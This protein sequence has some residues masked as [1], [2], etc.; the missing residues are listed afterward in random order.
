MYHQL[1]D[2][3]GEIEVCQDPDRHGL[4][5]GELA[6]RPSESLREALS[7]EGGMVFI[8]STKEMR[9]APSG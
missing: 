2:I 4:D 1:R 9:V 8:L 7:G 6:L 5:G 3:V